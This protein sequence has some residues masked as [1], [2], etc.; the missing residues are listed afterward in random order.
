[1]RIYVSRGA[2]MAARAVSDGR[3]ISQ[4]RSFV[5][6]GLKLLDLGRLAKGRYRVV[7]SATGDAGDTSTDRATLIVR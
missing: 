4:Q 7:V 3:A 6:A 5:R 2:T 1:M